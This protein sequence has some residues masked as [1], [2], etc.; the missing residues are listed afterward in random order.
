MQHGVCNAKLPSLEEVPVVYQ[1]KDDAVVRDRSRIT[2]AANLICPNLARVYRLSESSDCHFGGALSQDVGTP[3]EYVRVF[4]PIK[5]RNATADQCGWPGQL[6]DCETCVDV[7]F[8]VAEADDIVPLPY[9]Y[10]LTSISLQPTP[11]VLPGMYI[12]HKTTS[13]QG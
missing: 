11:P 12:P 7:V 6:L 4:R 5:R 10:N 9:P 13:L 1:H 8:R 3:I 2:S